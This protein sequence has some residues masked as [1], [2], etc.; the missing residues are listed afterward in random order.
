[1]D[2]ETVSCPAC[3]FS[4][5]MPAGTIP[6][7]ARVTCPRCRD[8]FMF[9]RGTAAGTDPVPAIASPLGPE[10][11]VAAPAAPS[12]ARPRT[13]RFSFTCTAREY[14]GIWIVNTLLK[15][16]TLGVYS[17]WAKVRKRRY[18][19]GNTM[20]HGAP[21]D[22]LANPR[23][24]FRGWLIGVL[25]FLLYTLGT[26]Y[27]P[28]LSFAVGALFFA[29]VPWLVVRSRLF[30]LRNTSYRNLRFTFR[31][32]YRQAYLVYGLLSLL[33]PLTL[34]LLYPY[35][36]YRRK[37]FLVENS[38]YGTTSFSFTTTTRDFYL[39]YLKAVAGFV[40]IVTV[41]VPL[42]FLAGG[43]FLP[44]GTGGPWRLAIVLPAFLIPLAYLYFAIYVSTNET[45][46]TWNGTQVAGARFTCSLRARHM[47]WLYLSNAVAIF[48]T[49]GLMIP[50]A[51][52]RVLRY[53]MESLTVLA[54]GDLQE[55]A[56]APAEEVAATG[57]EIGDIFG[58]DVAL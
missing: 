42:L 18:L 6:G 38:G 12:T 33:V 2:R 52:V 41:A 22:Y 57:E 45:N 9:A 47:A 24:L 39:L 32:D 53:R 56:A 26:N 48:L 35:A 25:A 19:Y 15:I 43:A 34:G 50:W 49:M 27:S 21:F 44:A 51:T 10:A 31:A 46:L 11:A 20:L 1:M 37:R 13:L 54:T 55:F 29:A 3:G 58:I 40:A 5:E 16:L 8:T 36:A 7:G 28:T 17:A 4:R 14:F 30:N 23:A